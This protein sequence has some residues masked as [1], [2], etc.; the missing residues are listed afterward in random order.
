MRIYKLMNEYNLYNQ[1][2]L[3]K[4]KCIVKH[5]LFLKKH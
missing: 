3:N 1:E 2:N 4:L 5:H